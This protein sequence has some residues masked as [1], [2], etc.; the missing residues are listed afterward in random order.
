MR[1]AV[2]RGPKDLSVE[3]IA[4]PP[5]PPGGAVLKVLAC[6][7]C[8]TDIK[9]ARVGQR[10]LS[11]PRVLGHEVVGSI[12]TSDSPELAVGDIVQVWPGIA[13]GKCASCLK[14]QD[15]M[16]SNQGILGFNRD[17][18]FAERMAV[19]GDT[20]TGRGVN[21]VPGGMD[22][23]VATFTEPLACCVHG[24]HM[25]SV[26]SGDR[27]AVFGSGPMGLMH[28]ALASS[29]GAAVMVIEPDRGR[30]ELSLRMG[31]ERAVDPSEEDASGAILDWSGGRGADVAL[32]ATPR[33]RADDQLMRAMAPRGR[34]CAF[35][36]LPRDDSRC[37]V[38]L[39]LLHYRELMLV[40]A[41]GCTSTSDAEAL[42]MLASGR[43]DLRPLISRRMP[44]GSI[45]EAFRSIEE[46]VALKCII[47]DLT[48]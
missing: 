20:I 9:M 11:Y 4:E 3:E 5:C 7:V 18:G 40:G 47:D 30:R 33:V 23:S 38:D 19:P 12:E 24:Q 42:G 17:G 31:A 2:L 34:I 22:P 37:A 26:A 45:E 32:L 8:P 46:R 13:C 36:G 14:G 16:C 27:V 35:S 44:L 1:A 6:A 43:I 39:N 29:K 21:A 41:Y 48:R 10:D 15:N 25:A 28:T